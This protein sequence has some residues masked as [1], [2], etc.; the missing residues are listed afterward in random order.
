MNAFSGLPDLRSQL[1]DSLWKVGLDRRVHQEVLPVLLYDSLI[2]SADNLPFSLVA[3]HQLM[4]F[5]DLL[6]WKHLL[7]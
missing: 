6:P 3:L 5:H 2:N 4:C 1:D 7:N